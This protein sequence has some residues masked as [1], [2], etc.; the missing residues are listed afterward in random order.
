[1]S[2]VRRFGAAALMLLCWAVGLASPAETTI[3]L[4]DPEVYKLDWNTRGLVAHDINGDG[5][6]DLAVLNN[7]R[8]KIDLLIQREAGRQTG[9]RRRGRSARRWEPV[10]EDA[11]FEKRS[12][13]TGGSMFALAVGDLDGDG[14]VDLAFTGKPQPLTVMYQGRDDEWNRKRVLEIDEPVHWAGSLHI[15]DLD[16][17]DRNDLVV[18][19]QAEVLVFRQDSEGA[20]SGPRRYPLADEGCYG[21]LVRDLNGDDRPDLM[22]LA[23]KSKFAW[24]VRFQEGKGGFGPERGF[25]ID[26][27]ATSLIPLTRNGSRFPEFVAVQRRTRLMETIALESV[28]KETKAGGP[29]LRPRV[30]STSG[31]DGPAASYALGDFDADG[32]LDVA[33]GLGGKAKVEIYLQEE[34]VGFGVPTTYPSLPDIRSIAAGDVDGDGAA[35]LFVLSSDEAT[36]GVSHVSDT[37]RMSYPRALPIT[38]R[39]L[40]LAAGH[41][42]DGA[43]LQ[44]AY[45]FEDDGQRGVG[46]L[47]PSDGGRNW[48]EQ[49][50]ELPG[51]RTDPRALRIVDANQDGLFDL[52]VFIVQSP[53]R[54]LLQQP[55][56]GFTEASADNGFRPGLVD[57]LSAS[58]LTLGDLDGDG[59]P[60]MLV[61]HKGFA[62]S[63]RLTSEG[64][65][66]VLDQFNARDSNA[67]ID[68]AVAVDLDD[69][70]TP[71]ILLVDD[72]QSSL[73]LLRRDEQGVYRYRESVPVGTIEF[74]GS[75]VLDLNHNGR[76][77]LLFYGR[78]RFWW[79][80]VGP[81]ELRI[82][83]ISTYETDL[84]GMSYVALAAGDLDNDG[85]DEIIAVD[86]L[87][88]RMM[89]VLTTDGE[90]D[91]R[92]ALHF[93]IF[94]ADPHYQGR[95]GAKAEP[96]EIVVSDV[97][98]DGKP[99]LAMLIH[100]RVLVYPQD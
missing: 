39:P 31:G 21:L 65:L 13:V 61:A 36:V 74:I 70:G 27:P 37:G 93:E 16:N 47:S 11:R 22:Y 32:L 20:L 64:S 42:V 38:G 44:I 24:R 95:R 33:V 5:R 49:R 8:A 3:L 87:E 43:G 35:E 59:K 19:T 90:N 94:E 100:D 97:T 67:G 73:Q 83:K 40:A 68:A 23:P 63:L 18:L 86:S 7:D 69:D 82:N 30:F 89:E 62:R 76:P 99:D 72:E 55:D 91:W 50:H 71:E 52:A 1:M 41:I 29:E 25:R 2:R 75:D 96:R 4:G 48:Q 58:A 28:D 92:S 56:G 51:L 84:E 12:V 10:L 6:I 79:I 57:N 34:G 46:I 77:D 54:L 45:L 53:M 17:D 98:G 88:S 78:D 15:H 14:R 26:S 60:E 80:P 85:R 9:S 66:E 81:A